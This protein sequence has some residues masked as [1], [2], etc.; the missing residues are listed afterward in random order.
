MEYRE[1]IK[2]GDKLSALGFGTMRLPQV[3]K[4]IDEAE[5]IRILRLAYE[6]GINYFDTAYV[7]NDG[8]SE[9]VLGKAIMPFREK[10]KIA[11]KLPLRLIKSYEDFDK[12]FYTSLKRLNTTYVDYYLLHCIISYDQYKHMV[13]LGVNDWIKQKKESKEIVNIGFSFHGCGDDFIKVIDAYDWEFCQIQYNYF[14]VNYQAGQ[15]G[16]KYAY[17]K[18]IPVIIME[19]LRGG[20]LVNKL[21]EKAQKTFKNANSTRSFA[22]WGLRWL[23]NQKEVTLVLS[24]MGSEAM[25]LSNIESAS[26]S[27]I[28]ELSKSE[29]QV[30][31]KVINEMLLADRIPCTG[32]SYCMPCPNGVDI[33]ACFSVYNSKSLAGRIQNIGNYVSSCGGLGEKQ[34]FASQCIG[35]RLCEK[36]CPQAIKISEELKKVKKTFEIPLIKP[37]I[38]LV[39][40]F[41]KF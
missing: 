30:Y 11:T 22:D 13:D 33:P 40:K 9:E 41:K 5:S 32:C 34:G 1:N 38:R 20:A 35:C 19:P 6:K 29:L 25:L 21:P 4:E 39:K 14:D 24:G 12:L 36:R 8:R 3:K 27:K 26:T 37:I 17:S 2:N 31:D 23:Y 18:Q 10:V 28:A 7:Y 15:K 16:L